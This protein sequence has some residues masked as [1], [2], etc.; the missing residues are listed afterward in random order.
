[1]LRFEVSGETLASFRE[2]M[3]QLRRE[4][5]V[6]LNDDAVLLLLARRVLGGPTDDGRASYQVAVDVGADCQRARQVADGEAI[7]L[8]SA[9]SEMAQCDAQQ[10]SAHVGAN[11]N[12]APTRA[13]QDVAPAT[14]RAVMRRDRRHCQ[15][16]GCAH[17]TWVDVHQCPEPSPQGRDASISVMALVRGA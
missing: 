2:A 10:V 1:V 17:G 3:A 12:R 16:P 13:A 9:A 15:V 4:A 7:A 6:H 11:D 8:S 14:R 5:G